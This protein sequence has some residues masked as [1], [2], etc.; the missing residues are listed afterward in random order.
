MSYHAALDPLVEACVGELE[1]RGH[2]ITRSR[3][4]AVR[5]VSARPGHFTAEELRRE[6]PRLGRATVYRNIKLL[7]EAG[8]LCRVLLEDG[9]RPY[10][11]SHRSH[12]HHLVCVQCGAVQDLLDCDVSDVLRSLVKRTG[13][14]MEGHR[15]EVYGRCRTCRNARAAGRAAEH[16]HF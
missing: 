6:L 9:S 1:A 2:R 10:R 14:E 11:L 8:F 7:Q 5:A 13:F 12:H 16:R 4:A 15:L 3:R